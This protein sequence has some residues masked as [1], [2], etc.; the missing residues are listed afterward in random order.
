[1]FHSIQIRYNAGKVTDI[2]IKFDD[3]DNY[4]LLDFFDTFTLEDLVSLADM[5]SRFRE[6]VIKHYAVK[7]FQFHKKLIEVG[8]KLNYSEEKIQIGETIKILDPYT[9]IIFLRNFGSIITHIRIQ[10]PPDSSD[11]IWTR[12]IN[13]YINEYCSESLNDLRLQSAIDTVDEWRKPF[14]RLTALIIEQETSSHDSVIDFNETFP[15]LQYLQ[16]SEC[17]FTNL[18]LFEHHFPHL[19][20]ISFHIIEHGEHNTTLYEKFFRLNPQIRIAGI[21]EIKSKNFFRFL[22][23]R[24]PQIEEIKFS[25][26]FRDFLKTNDETTDIIHFKGIKKCLMFHFYLPAQ[27][28]FPVAFDELEKLEIR[29]LLENESTMQFIMQHRSLKILKLLLCTFNL[30]QW[31][32]LLENLPNLVEIYRMWQPMINDDP[33]FAL[34][35]TEITV[36][37][38]VMYGRIDRKDISSRLTN[39]KW[40]IQDDS[41]SFLTTFIRQDCDI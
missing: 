18:K 41:H 4:L 2:K 40:R 31:M 30:N 13:K 8:G 29:N 24:L 6:L 35:A 38:F 15:S 37:K 3:L 34:M 20:S 32:Q 21:E 7:K 1:M 27:T 36:K 33:V 26:E 9:A 17:Q 16:I 28:V 12:R 25:V 14:K 23:S 19:D 22:K 10:H 5:N 11:K 39:L